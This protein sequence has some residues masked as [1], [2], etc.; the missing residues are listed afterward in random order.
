[1]AL[2]LALKQGESFFIGQ[3]DKFTVCK[4]FSPTK[5]QLIKH[6]PFDEKITITSNTSSEIFPDVH[7][8]VG[9]NS[10]VYSAKVSLEAPR[11]I[12][13]LREEVILNAKKG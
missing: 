1:M 8:F 10:S 6:G 9:S 5:V 11:R 3:N 12:T 7:A 4:I 13:I 2:I